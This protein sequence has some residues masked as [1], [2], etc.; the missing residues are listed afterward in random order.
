MKFV[1][2]AAL[3]CLLREKTHHSLNEWEVYHVGSTKKMQPMIWI[4]F[5]YVE[6][7][8]QVGQKKKDP[9]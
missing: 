5:T 9:K 7:E 1:Q 4:C 8:I 2:G 3:H 6:Q